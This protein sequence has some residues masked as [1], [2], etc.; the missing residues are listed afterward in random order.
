M[1][2]KNGLIFNLGI[3]FLLGATN[4]ARANELK[5]IP[6]PPKKTISAFQAA[7][8]GPVIKFGS[9][10]FV[11]LPDLLAVRGLGEGISTVRG[12]KEWGFDAAEVVES[13]G[14]FIIFR[15]EKN[16]DTEANQSIRDHGGLSV[17]PVVLNPRTGKAG[18]V[19]GTLIVRFK[20]AMSTKA[21]AKA[22]GLKL[23]NESPPTRTAF[24]QVGL[25]GNPFTVADQL[26]QDPTVN[27]VEI[28]VLENPIVPH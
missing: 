1:T 9:E 10:T 3:F 28:E 7:P 6:P 23:R 27:S 21:M 18:V 26:R 12:L 5:P 17:H 19:M 16:P 15:L 11:L 2:F 22:Y 13:K 4:C 8:N 25:G 20:G 14:P 24:F